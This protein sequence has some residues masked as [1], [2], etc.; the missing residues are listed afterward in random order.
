MTVPAGEVVEVTLTC[1]VGYKGIVAGWRL[2]DG[3]VDLG[4]DPRPIIRVF[5]L[6]NPTSGPLTA[7]LWLGC[8]ATRTK[9][10]TGNPVVTNTASATT[11][12]P[13][14]TTGNNSGSAT[15][16]V[17]SGSAP[18]A[19]AAPRVA[20]SG[21]KVTAPVTCQVEVD[22]GG[23]ATLVA[24]KTQK[25]AGK[26]LKKGTVLAKGGYTVEAGSTSTVVLKAT[27]NGKKALKK[28]KKATLKLGK[29]AKKVK[30]R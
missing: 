21:S 19:P 10:G 23:T 11:T 22:C 1:P 8:L 13:E 28:V 5:K 25:V 6:F 3:L 26:K 29:K 2:D 20:V 9:S 4:N 17:Q 24:L 30:L 7:D 14:K 16:T 27:K 18:A 12:S 15:L